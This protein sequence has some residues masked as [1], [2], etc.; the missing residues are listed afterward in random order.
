MPVRQQET[1][2]LPSSSEDGGGDASEDYVQLVVGSEDEDDD[3]PDD[4]SVSPSANSE[5]ES[6]HDKPP[7]TPRKRKR[8]TT[9][10]VTST[11][12]RRRAAN[13]AAPTPHSKAAL[14][15]RALK[16][17]QLAVRPPP[18][19]SAA[20][21]FA[22]SVVSTDPWLRAMHVLHVASRPEG[23]GTRLPC[24]EGEYARVLTSV[25]ELLDE[26]S[27]G[28]VYISG[29][30]GTGKTATVHAVVRELK[31]MA[32]D[33]EANPFTF[34]EI[35]GLR[36][37]EPSAAYGLLWEAVSGHDA[38]KEGHLKISAKEALKNLGR[39]FAAGAGP[40]GH[41][42]YVVRFNKKTNL[43]LGI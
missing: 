18:G 9:T 32:E 22:L 28:C 21:E 25:E 35:N 30:P 12:R 4:A 34:V 43:G 36:I 26:G 19:P 27:G 7:R 17:R 23:T 1:V 41:A 39:Y 13:T 10:S 11:P 2:D 16:K 5:P 29:V 3:A 40:R 20:D 24:R 14:R 37:P 33:N 8:G 42:W 38:S 31:R 6:D 15:A